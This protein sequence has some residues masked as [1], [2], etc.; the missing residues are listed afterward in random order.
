MK[1]I[2][3][4]AGAVIALSDSLLHFSGRV[5]QSHVDWPEPKAKV[6]KSSKRAKVKAARKQKLR[7]QK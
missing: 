7:N 2:S 1:G 3:S 5:K 4:I 6:V